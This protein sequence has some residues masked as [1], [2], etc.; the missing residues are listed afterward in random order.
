MLLPNLTNHAKQ[1]L[2]Q[3]GVRRKALEIVMIYG[4]IEIPSGA[5]C[6]F[7]RL[8]NHAV[9]SLLCGEEHPVQAVDDAKRLLVLV[10]ASGKV[11]TLIKRD[12]ERR[13]RFKRRT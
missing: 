6:R 2:R 7:L 3:R 10:S 13:L 8:S 1:R 12:P 9:S 11:V 4:D 5:G